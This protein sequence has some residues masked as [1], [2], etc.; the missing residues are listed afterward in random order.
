MRSSFL[1]FLFGL[2]FW[3]PYFPYYI[4]LTRASLPLVIRSLVSTKPYQQFEPTLKTAQF[5][6]YFHPF[7][8]SIVS[9][10]CMHLKRIKH[11][12]QCAFRLTS[13]RIS[14][15]LIPAFFISSSRDLIIEDELVSFNNCPSSFLHTENTQAK[16]QKNRKEIPLLSIQVHLV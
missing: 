14:L 5:S 11:S 13:P 2:P 9:C 16:Q 12:M 1:A 15:Q 3:P 7:I 10:V 6:L 4:V 8:F